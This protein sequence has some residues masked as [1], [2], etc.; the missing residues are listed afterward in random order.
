MRQYA[1]QL[2]AQRRG[3]TLA[4]DPT[5]G[6]Q[7]LFDCDRKHCTPKAGTAPALSGWWS[8]RAP[9]PGDLDALCRASTIL[10][11]RAA[12][13]PPASCAHVLVV[14]P[15]DVARGGAAE[16]YAARSGWRLVWAQ[17]LRGARPWSV[18]SFSDSDG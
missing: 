3:F 8:T 5:P 11:I 16:I 2:W 10:V 15:D 14:G 7:A 9:K 12:V 13:A 18:A 6:Q 17:T 1:T 4:A